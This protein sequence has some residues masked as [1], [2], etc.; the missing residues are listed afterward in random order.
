MADSNRR[1]ASAVPASVDVGK[2]V[3]YIHASV[4]AAETLFEAGGTSRW[5]SKN[6]PCLIFDRIVRPADNLH[7]RIILHQINESLV[8]LPS[9]EGALHVRVLVL[10]PDWRRIDREAR[11][12]VPA[13]STEIFGHR[14]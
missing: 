7:S 3:K 8:Q 5:F 11:M 4:G 2:G 12:L 13:A 9:I 6:T 10:G 1:I 14:R